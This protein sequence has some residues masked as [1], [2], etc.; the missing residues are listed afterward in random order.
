MK[1]DLL[2]GMFRYPI[3]CYECLDGPGHLAFHLLSGG[4]IVTQKI[5]LFGKI[6][7]E[8]RY[9][10]VTCI[11]LSSLDEDETFSLASYTPTIDEYFLRTLEE[12]IHE[13]TSSQFLLVVMIWNT[14]AD[15]GWWSVR[16]LGGIVLGVRKALRLP[17]DPKA[18]LVLGPLSLILLRRTNELLVKEYGTLAERELFKRE[19]TITSHLLLTNLAVRS[20]FGRLNSHQISCAQAV[21]DVPPALGWLPPYEY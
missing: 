17:Y 2:R 20:I 16:D 4:F 7:L 14:L 15:N 19:T 5:T 9:M 11:I 13:V 8:G 18:T 12:D 21:G 10:R 1:K 6:P 3:S